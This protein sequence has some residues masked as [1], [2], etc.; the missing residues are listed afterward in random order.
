M[1]LD[2][3]QELQGL[4]SSVTASLVLERLEIRTSFFFFCLLFW[5]FSVSLHLG[6]ELRLV[7][8]PSE[9]PL[10]KPWL[11]CLWG[12]YCC[13]GIF[14]FW[15]LY[16]YWKTDIFSSYWMCREPKFWT[17]AW[18]TGDCLSLRWF[19]SDFI[20]VSFTLV[21]IEW[22]IF[23][24]YTGE[25]LKKRPVTLLLAQSPAAFHKANFSEVSP[26]RSCDLSVLNGSL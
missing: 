12:F 20:H 23:S 18:R 1:L 15:L 24:V 7:S 11:W 3:T 14:G 25:C 8:F 21:K 16:F 9:L 19:S 26:E 4:F 10:M 22:W 17:K 6:N 13:T 5:N 2:S